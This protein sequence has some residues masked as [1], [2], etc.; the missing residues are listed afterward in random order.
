MLV[1]G[2]TEVAGY[3]DVENEFV[4]NETDD[5]TTMS[6]N[7]QA[8]CRPFISLEYLQHDRGFLT[9][10]CARASVHAFSLNLSIK[11]VGHGD[12]FTCI[13]RMNSIATNGC[14][15]KFRC[16]NPCQ[17]RHCIRCLNAT[18]YFNP[19]PRIEARVHI[20]L[21][22]MY[23]LY[24]KNMDIARMHLEKAFAIC[25]NQTSFEDAI[26]ECACLLGETYMKLVGIRWL[27]F[28]GCFV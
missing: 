28:L 12:P 10:A 27:L 15:E 5:E 13:I 16:S 14:T 8:Y 17:P 1:R 4:T 21:G 22:S 23:L 3:A 2:Q 9:Y 6:L 18:F 24:S 20:Q 25:Q 7:A 19:P 11:L 26:A